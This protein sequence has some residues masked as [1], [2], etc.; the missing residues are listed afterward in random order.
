MEG[1][2]ERICMATMCTCWSY[3]QVASKPALAPTLAAANLRQQTKVSSPY[4]PPGT[5]PERWAQL[6]K[7]EKER[8]RK[9]QKRVVKA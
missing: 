2:C 6:E 5:S 8:E 1:D 4:T 9:A 3:E 7:Q